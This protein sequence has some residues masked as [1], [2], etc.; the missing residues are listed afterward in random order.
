[1]R[2]LT[3]GVITCGRPEKI[4]RCLECIHASIDS[5][6]IV[7][8]VDSS[9]NEESQHV[10]AKFPAYRIIRPHAMLGPSAARRILC[11]N[12]TTEFLLLL[13]DDIE[14]T[15]QTVAALL[16]H[17]EEHP[18]TDIVTA[19][20]EEYGSMREAGQKLVFGE[21][22][23][24]PVVLRSLIFLSDLRRAGVSSV[25]VDVGHGTMMLRTRILEH[26]AFDPQFTF[27]YELLDFYMQCRAHGFR[28]DTT[29]STMFVHKPTRYRVA[30]NRQSYDKNRAIALFEDKWNLR[31]VG[32]LG[33]TSH[34]EQSPVRRLIRCISSKLR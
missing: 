32:P 29:T 16:A 10:Y 24:G 17:L 13:D 1:M 9:P 15:I 12:A 25:T 3:I 33:A 18:R 22:P 26:V 7:S 27:Y 4:R 5:N 21:G 19:A 30:T 20:W 31:P 23:G 2:N 8:V 14:I 11:E 28:V 34:R 6:T